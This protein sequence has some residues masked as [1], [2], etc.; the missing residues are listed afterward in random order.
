VSDRNRKE[1][2]RA[3][4]ADD[5]LRRVTPLDISSRSYK[6][7]GASR[8]Y[9]GPVAQDCYAAFGLG[10]DPTSNALD[11]GGVTLAAVQAL[12]KRSENATLRAH[13]DD[14][15]TLRAARAEQRTQRPR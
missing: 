5:T 4:N 11:M 7:T 3:V 2:F 13:P 8:R 15:A 14:L 6:G 9:I 1:F 10:T 12:G